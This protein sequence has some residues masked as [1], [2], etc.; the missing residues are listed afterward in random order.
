MIRIYDCATAAPRYCCTLFISATWL[1][2]CCYV[3]KKFGQI[4]S[5]LRIDVMR[6]GQW[7]K[8]KLTKSLIKCFSIPSFK[9]HFYKKLGYQLMKWR[10]NLITIL[11]RSIS[12]NMSVSYCKYV[13]HIA[14]LSMLSYYLE[15]FR[16][17]NVY[18]TC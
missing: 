16:L 13:S 18:K 7:S 5:T 4:P 12:V 1:Q 17:G 14:L 11:C 6:S 10:L 2:C 15:C 8:S 3:V 9:Y